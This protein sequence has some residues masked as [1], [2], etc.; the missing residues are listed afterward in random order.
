MARKSGRDSKRIEILSQDIRDNV[1]E[2]EDYKRHVREVALQTG[3][4]EDAINLVLS[5]FFLR[6][7]K[8]IYSLRAINKRIN[9]YGFFNLE[10][11]KRIYNN[12]KNRNNDK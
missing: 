5:D 6:V 8:V 1:L 3:L 4:P 12:L 10:I 2:N 9:F 11:K 7:P